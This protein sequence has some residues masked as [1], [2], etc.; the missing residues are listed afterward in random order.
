MSRVGWLVGCPTFATS[1]EKAFSSKPLLVPWSNTTSV[2]G[3]GDG[4][5]PQTGRRCSSGWVGGGGTLLLLLLGRGPL[6]PP[7]RLPFNP[8]PVRPPPSCR[9]SIGGPVNTGSLR[10]WAVSCAC[11]HLMVREGG[12]GPTAGRRGGGEPLVVGVQ[13]GGEEGGWR[14]PVPTAR[15]VASSS[16]QGFTYLH[17]L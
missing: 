9:L 13:D 14:V 8:R 2:A 1:A 4:L 10:Q 16:N 7:W 17:V 11:Q 12:R 6:C 5:A 15:Q 3:G